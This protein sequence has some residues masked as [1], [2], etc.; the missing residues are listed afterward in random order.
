VTDDEEPPDELPD[1]ALVRIR[2]APDPP[3]P[4]EADDRDD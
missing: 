4:S 3:P 2:L 1:G